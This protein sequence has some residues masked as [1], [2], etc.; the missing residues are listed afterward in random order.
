MSLITELMYS[1]R[2]S[3]EPGLK[4]FGGTME[5][6]SIPISWAYLASSLESAIESA[7]TCAIK[8]IVYFFSL[9]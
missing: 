2:L 3:I 8:V 1:I 5:V 6:A 9:T 7:P 4:K